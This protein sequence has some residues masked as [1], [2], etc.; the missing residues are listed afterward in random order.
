MSLHAG[1]VNK[2]IARTNNYSKSDSGKGST[3]ALDDNMGNNGN[4]QHEIM[5]PM[6]MLPSATI[7]HLLA[8]GPALG[9]TQAEAFW[10]S[11]C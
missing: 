8:L 9:I 3:F 11:A 6:Q 2:V 1:Q 4:K 5:N 7:F 10:V